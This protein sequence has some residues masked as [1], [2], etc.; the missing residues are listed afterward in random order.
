MNELKR[1]RKKKMEELMK[2]VNRS[3]MEI[4]IKVNNN[5]FKKE[6]IERSKQIPVVVDF[7]AQWCMPCRMLG[8]MLEKL[9]KEYNGKFVLAKANV[10]DSRIKAM[11]Y[12]VRGIPAVK[13]FKNGNVSDEF[14]GALSESQVREWLNKNLK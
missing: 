3:Q 14:V 4:E 7:W 9:V 5:N 12:E 11:E 8:P 1:I 13:M 2:K 10:E 6:V